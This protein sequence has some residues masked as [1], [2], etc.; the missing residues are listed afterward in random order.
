MIQIWSYGI[1]KQPKQK[2]DLLIVSYCFRCIV[3]FPRKKHQRCLHSLLL[4]WQEGDTIRGDGLAQFGSTRWM[5]EA[6]ESFQRWVFPPFFCQENRIFLTL[7]S[8]IFYHFQHGKC[9]LPE[10][11]GTKFTLFL[12]QI[13][14]K[15]DPR[16][17]QNLVCIL[18]WVL[19]HSMILGRMRKD[20]KDRSSTELVGRNSS[21]A[22]ND[23]S[24]GRSESMTNQQIDSI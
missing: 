18:S 6:T 7:P 10:V 3:F 8:W 1:C 24:A 15:G 21:K 9:L 11:A 2:F 22:L 14:L 17:N 5:M 20:K 13:S 23:K 19:F 4:E 12:P 16:P